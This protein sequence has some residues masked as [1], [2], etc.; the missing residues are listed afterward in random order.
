M[1]R[2]YFLFPSIL[3]VHQN[4][5]GQKAEY[6]SDIIYRLASYVEWPTENTEYKFVIGV[7]G[8]VM[9]FRSFQRLALDKHNIN[10]V[11]IEIR[12]F[13]RADR[14]PGGMS[15]IIHFRKM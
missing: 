13:D 10:H 6:H 8:N 14:S 15:V 5:L 4:A 11:P 3:I 2:F 9:D 12:Y 1:F 7:I